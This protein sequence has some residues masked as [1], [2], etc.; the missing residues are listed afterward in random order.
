MRERSTRWSRAAWGLLIALV[1]CG[2]MPV[3]EQSRSTDPSGRLDAIVVERGTDATVATPTQVFIASRGQTITPDTPLKPVVIADRVRKA[4]VTWISNGRLRV[5]L[6][7]GRVFR[8][9][10]VDQ[11]GGVVVEV[12]LDGVQQKPNP[13]K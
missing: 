7:G 4:S 10:G 12:R 1:G 5:E 9:R 11:P 13:E 3:Y 6:Q 2:S 8:H